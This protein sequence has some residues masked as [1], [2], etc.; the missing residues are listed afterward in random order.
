MHADSFREFLS[1][2]PILISIAV[3]VIMEKV[4]MDANEPLA[5]NQ[6]ITIKAL[7]AARNSIELG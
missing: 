7:S 3:S 2:V 5:P 1:L 4:E 6:R